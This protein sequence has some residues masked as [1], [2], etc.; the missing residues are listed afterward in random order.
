MV[1][2]HFE[3]GLMELQPPNIVGKYR[4]EIQKPV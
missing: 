1:R 3:M 2:H 4:M